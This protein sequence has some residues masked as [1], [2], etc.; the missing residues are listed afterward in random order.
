MTNPLLADAPTD[1]FRDIRPE[2]LAPAFEVLVPRAEAALEAIRSDEGPP[3][4]DNTFGA[5]E[6]ATHGMDQAFSAVQFLVGVRFS[7]ELHAAVDAAMPAVIGIHSGIPLDQ[8]LYDRLRAFAETDAAS[9]LGSEQARLMTLTLDEF[10]RNG[11]ELAPEAQERLRALQQELAEATT[12]FA[13]RA[14]QATSAWSSEV[15]EDDLEGTPPHVLAMAR[16]AAKAEGLDG[17][18]LKLQ[19]P[20]YVGVVRHGARRDVRERIW[21]G[22]N[23]R[24]ASAPHDNRE[25]VPR[26]LQLRAEIAAVLGY[27]TYADYV[28]ENRMATRGATADAFIR[29]LESRARDG[30]AAEQTMLQAAFDAEIGEGEMGPWDTGWLSERIRQERFAFDAEKLR[31]YLERDQV[32]SGLFQLIERVFGVDVRPIEREA[33]HEDVTSWALHDGDRVLGT[34]FLDLHPRGDKRAG[35]WMTPMVHAGWTDDGW[36]PHLAAICANLTPPDAD[37]RCLLTHGE[38]ETIFHEFGHL[39]HHLLSEVRI[40]SLG[41]TSVA[42]DFVE[43]PSQIMQNWCWEREALDLF[44]R[45]V[46]T[47]EPVPDELFDA[48]MAARTFRGASRMLMQV[49]YARIDLDLHMKPAPDDLLGTVRDTLQR[50]QIGDL[51]DSYSPITSFGHLFSSP[52]GYAAGYYSYQWAEVLDADAFTRFA[53]NG[54]FDAETGI[55]FRKTILSRGN[56]EDPAVLFERFMGRAPNPGAHLYRYGLA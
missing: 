53:D 40:R 27:D 37:G 49:G 16:E 6:D 25:E 11:A 9:Q 7:P 35:G 10:R 17:Y 30:F 14:L 21:R 29:D 12:R 38:V 39:L 36:R 24:G 41:G 56:S 19:A 43:L 55:A 1:H 44:A 48:M 5:L 42:W 33:W 18:L 13:A 8:A 15:T 28:L 3:T 2:H 50:F 4:W 23:S 51:P 31:P 45:H 32:L 34:F 26:I 52:T 20:V 22:W 46:D 47:G 54:I